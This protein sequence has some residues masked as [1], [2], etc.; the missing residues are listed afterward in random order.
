MWGIDSAAAVLALHN[1]GDDYSVLAYEDG[2]AEVKTAAE[3][4]IEPKQH[5][6]DFFL[7]TQRRIFE[8][9]VARGFSA[10][11]QAPDIADDGSLSVYCAERD[12]PYVNVEARHGEVEAQAEMLRQVY[13]LFRGAR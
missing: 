8:A 5:R 6:H 1:T 9:L 2:G 12:I 11:L 3:V 7:V 13:P 10:I 4:H